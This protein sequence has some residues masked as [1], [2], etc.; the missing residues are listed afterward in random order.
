MIG[1]VTV[2]PTEATANRSPLADFGAL[3]LL[4]ASSP[5]QIVSPGDEIP[6]ELLWQAGQGA[7]LEPLVVVVQLVDEQGNVVASLEEQP[8]LGRYPT[9]DWLGEYEL[10][11]DRHRLSVPDDAPS[12]KYQLIAGVYRADT[13]ERLETQSGPL[14]LR[15]SD[16]AVIRQIEIR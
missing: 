9:T 12:G 1:P 8:L 16:H 3:R 4:Q 6:V 11:R 15:S 2:H 13:H 10:V 14:G 5:A 7:T